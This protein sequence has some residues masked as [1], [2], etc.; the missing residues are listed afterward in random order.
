MLSNKSVKLKIQVG[1]TFILNG[2]YHTIDRVCS[3]R[4]HC[5][6]QEGGSYYITYAYFQTTPHFK[7]R[8]LN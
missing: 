8:Y 7:S 3:D 4:L 1:Y 5:R 6:T 2:V